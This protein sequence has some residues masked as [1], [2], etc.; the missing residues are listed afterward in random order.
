V[1]AKLVKVVSNKYLQ[2]KKSLEGKLKEFDKYVDKCS[3]LE[4]KFNLFSNTIRNV[5]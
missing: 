3:N 2:Y 4:D 5:N 1:Q